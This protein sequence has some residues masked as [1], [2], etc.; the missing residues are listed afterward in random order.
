MAVSSFPIESSLTDQD[1]I[2]RD[3]VTRGLIVLPPEELGIDTDIHDR[4]YTKEKEIF[5]ARESVTASRIPEVLEVINAPGLVTACNLILGENWAIVPYTHN[6]PFV[7]GS[8]DQ[9]WHKD[10]NGPYNGR[11]QRHHQTGFLF[12]QCERQQNIILPWNHLKYNALSHL[13]HNRH[14]Q[15]LP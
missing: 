14:H 5:R 9:H 15:E 6:A 10:D 8:N 7:S 1:Q 11:K 3:F 12:Y 13:E 2:I 4:I